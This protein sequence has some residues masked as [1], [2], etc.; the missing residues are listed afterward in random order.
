MMKKIVWTHL[1]IVLFFALITP[2]YASVKMRAVI[3]QDVRVVFDF[4]NMNST[5]YW[6]IK[7]GS[8]I[9]PSTIPNLIIENLAQRDLTAVDFH[10][11]LIDF[12]N[13][14]L[15]MHVAFTLSGSDVVNTKV[16]TT[17]MSRT[18][19]V[20]T[21][22][23]K[24]QLNITNGISLILDFADFYGRPVEQWQRIDYTLNDKV[25][26]AYYYNFT[27]QNPLDSLGY[28]ILPAEATNIRLIQDTVTFDLPLSFEDSLLNSPF[29]IFGGLIVVIAAFSL[30][31]RI[32]K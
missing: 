21:D 26:P 2:V 31:R 1:L 19:N 6:A 28:F 12:D 14:S 8:L 23:R 4:E 25:H 9:T 22:W 18:Y 32:R 5:V 16:N 29:L 27:G 11:E 10:S 3:D 7:N 17:T 20:R 13:S 15:S 30:Y 24:F